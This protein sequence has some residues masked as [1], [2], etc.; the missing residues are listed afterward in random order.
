LDDVWSVHTFR[1]GI[2][3]N[4]KIVVDFN[5]TYKHL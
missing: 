2:K 4:C 3:L 1:L 5:L